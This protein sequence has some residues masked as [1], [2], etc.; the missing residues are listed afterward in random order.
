MPSELNL[1]LC[2]TQPDLSVATWTGCIALTV[3]SHLPTVV[4]GVPA[5]HAQEPERTPTQASPPTQTVRIEDLTRMA[6]MSQRLKQEFERQFPQTTI[7]LQAQSPGTHLQ[8]LLDSPV[9]LAAI[10]R[11]L[12]A[13]EQQQGWVQVPIAREKLAIVVGQDNPFTQGLTIDQVVKIFQGDITNWSQV[14][15]PPVA[16]RVVTQAS[17][18]N[19]RGALQ[20]Y[21]VFGN[22][23]LDAGGK[24]I[25][26]EPN[27]TATLAQQ[28]GQDGIGYAL[29][30]HVRHQQQLRVVPMGNTLAEDE[31]YPFSQPLTL[32]HQGNPRPSV[33]AFLDFV[34]AEPG[35]GAIATAQTQPGPDSNANLVEA[36]PLG[37][38]SPSQFPQI[39]A[40][41]SPSQP[42]P[43][44][45]RPA[46][47]EPATG[48]T[49]GPGDAVALAD[50]DAPAVSASPSSQPLWLPASLT[51]LVLGGIAGGLFKNRSEARQQQRAQ[52]PAP[53]Y[54]ARLKNP[55]RPQWPEPPHAASPDDSPDLAATSAATETATT[56]IEPGE[57]DLTADPSTTTDLDPSAMSTPVDSNP[58]N[59]GDP[60]P[61][62]ISQEDSVT[63]SE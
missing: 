3:L 36:T 15:G 18:S 56:D 38:A 14:G 16:I 58:S 61:P 37:A 41:L 2:G 53:D 8:A 54:A 1:C 23:A 48:G 51:A 49:I 32:V 40:T 45:T 57:P 62:Q 28:L 35:Q 46:E 9:D 24:A 55:S 39:T 20:R 10:G 27:R 5:L 33:Q 11:P 43:T 50:I 30:S 22:Q 44:A 31:R 13:A 19:N 25:E 52:K 4:L 17:T 26:I 7:D 42:T 47:T 63:G 6:P 59:Q 12:T 60:A 34:Q 29:A 21:P